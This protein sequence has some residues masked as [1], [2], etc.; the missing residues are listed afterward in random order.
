MY[1]LN[2]GSSIREIQ[3]LFSAFT[4]NS[5]PNCS[6]G[7]IWSFA[8]H[9]ENREIEPVRGGS[10]WKYGTLFN[11]SISQKAKNTMCDFHDFGLT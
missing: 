11:G 10:I 2:I 9:N 4:K 5:W 6:D 8:P 1:V 3:L 7:H